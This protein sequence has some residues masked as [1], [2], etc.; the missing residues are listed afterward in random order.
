MDTDFT[1]IYTTTMPRPRVDRSE[2][3]YQHNSKYI[4]LFSNV[5]HEPTLFRKTSKG[6]AS[7][8]RAA[9]KYY[10]MCACSILSR[11]LANRTQQLDDHH[12]TASSTPAQPPGAKSR[13]HHRSTYARRAYRRRRSCL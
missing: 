12:T 9:T 4:S 8:R 13:A 1:C 11:T 2:D 3:S 5:T 10:S 6:R 7:H